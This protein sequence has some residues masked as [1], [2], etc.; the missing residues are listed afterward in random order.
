MFYY[1]HGNSHKVIFPIIVL[2]IFFVR[3]LTLRG[4]LTGISQLFKFDI[5]KINSMGAWK[6]AATQTFFNLGLGKVYKF[7]EFEKFFFAFF[8]HEFLKFKMQ[9]MQNS[10][11]I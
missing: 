2:F 5:A 6:D 3:S 10:Q 8:L 9:K 11:G 1:S 7:F 4:A